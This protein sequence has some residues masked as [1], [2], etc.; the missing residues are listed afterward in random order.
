V[1][2]SFLIILILFANL[3]YAAE[4]EIRF[5]DSQV[6][7]G[8]LVDAVLVF[9]YESSQKVPLSKLTGQSLADTF[10]IYSATPLMTKGDFN[11]LQSEAKVILIKSPEGDS[12]VHKLADVDL[13]I[14]WN[15]VKFIATE[16]SQTMLFGDFKIPGRSRLLFWISIALSLFGLIAISYFVFRKLKHKTALKKRRIDI[17]S[18]LTSASSYDEVVEIWKRKQSLVSEFPHLEIPYKNLEAVLFKYQFKPQRSESEKEE[19]IK[20]YREFVSQTQGGF[21][22]V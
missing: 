17:K 21:D 15:S 13:K 12:L 1:K 16:T 9:D 22:G 5:A 18:Q 20:A 2:K 19:V 4:V 14:T 8:S 6:K 7:Q 11:V 3:S 10:Y